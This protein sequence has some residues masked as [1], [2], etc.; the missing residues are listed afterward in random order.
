MGPIMTYHLG[1]GAGGLRYLLDHIPV[2][3]LWPDL[4]TPEMTPGFEQALIDGVLA[5]AG[6]KPIPEMAADRDRK[7]AAIL[8]GV[9]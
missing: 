2:D 9:R 7:L 8:E 4:G 6:G 1:G 3:K 5:E